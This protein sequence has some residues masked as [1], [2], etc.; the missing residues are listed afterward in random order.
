MAKPL[1]KNIWQNKL[2]LNLC[3]PSNPAAPFLGTYLKAMSVYIYQKPFTKMLIGILL[4]IAR[5]WKQ[6]KCL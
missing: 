1:C 4:I 6:L 5:N 3:V 2:K